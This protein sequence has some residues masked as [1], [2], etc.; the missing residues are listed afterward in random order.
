MPQPR[1]TAII[2]AG[3]AGLAMARELCCQGIEP[4][5]FEKSDD[6]GGTWNYDPMTESDPLGLDPTREVVHSSA[7]LSLRTNLPRQIMGFVD[8]PF[9]ED[10]KG[11]RRTFPGHEEVLR[12]VKEFAEEFGLRRL[13][14]FGCEVVRVGRR[15]ERWLWVVEWKR[16]RGEEVLVSEEIFEAVVVCNGHFTQPRVPTIPGIE[17][18]PGYQIHSHNYRVPEPFRDKVVVIIGFGASAF[19]ISRDIAKVAK[20][21]HLASRS[22]EI[23]VMKVPNHDNI[24]QHKMV[25]YVTEESLV[26]FEEGSSIHADVI[27]YC[28]GFKYHFPFLETNGIVTIEDNRVGPLYKHVFP[29]S[30]APTLSFIG[31][32]EKDLIFQMTDLQCKWVARVI[33]GK[34]K[35]PSE[36]E[37]MASV[38]EYY[39]QMEKNGYPKHTTHHLHFKESEYCNWLASE[40]GLPPVEDWKERMYVESL[41]SIFSMKDDYKDQWEDAYWDA[42]IKDASLSK[43]TI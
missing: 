36:K 9:R 38:E 18:W 11:D 7:Y 6:L 39:Q 20:E 21:V 25:K 24:W 14:R 30:L 35:L 3:I 42:I 31:L 22:P 34:V 26:A 32:T 27:L 43:C 40:V 13:V 19:D 16:K 17:K 41:K 33:S 8:Y 37:M 10:E 2:G 1:R 5:V 29:P 23:M 15:G 4:V 12:F 28:T